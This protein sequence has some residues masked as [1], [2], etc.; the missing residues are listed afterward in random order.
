MHR[1][2]M[3]KETVYKAC[4]ALFTNL[5]IKASSAVIN[6]CITSINA[7]SS[8]DSSTILESGQNIAS[9]LVVL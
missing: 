4:L 5:L 1:K 9:S 3:R 6:R 2:S 8:V 7:L